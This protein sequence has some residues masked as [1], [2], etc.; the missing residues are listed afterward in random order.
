MAVLLICGDIVIAAPLDRAAKRVQ[1]RFAFLKKDAD[2][3]RLFKLERA[4][5]PSAR[6]LSIADLRH[7]R[8]GA[9]RKLE[10]LR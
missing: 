2:A 7:R 9:Q 6:F 8:G 10:R 5:G 4:W 1:R 3:S